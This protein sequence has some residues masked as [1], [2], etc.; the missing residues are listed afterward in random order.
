MAALASGVKPDA[1]ARALRSVTGVAGRYQTYEIDGRSVRMLMA[2]NPAGW[3]E[4]MTMVSHGASQLVSAVSGQIPDGED[5]S[6]L[7]DVD[8]A[9]LRKQDVGTII[10]SGERAADLAVRLE[11]AGFRCTVVDSPLE[12]VKTFQPGKVEVLANYS[13]FRDLKKELDR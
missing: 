3:Q 9:A 6:W 8:F 5:L 10:A 4:A 12:A 13:A 1:L 11:Y 2:K 7:W